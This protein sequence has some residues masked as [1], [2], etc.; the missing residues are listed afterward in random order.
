MISQLATALNTLH[1]ENYQSST[2][3]MLN[4]TLLVFCAVEA[5]FLLASYKNFLLEMRASRMFFSMTAL[6]LATFVV[7]AI[8]YFY[9]PEPHD[10]IWILAM[11]LSYVGF[12]SVLYMFIRYLVV[13]IQE[14][15]RVSSLVSLTVL[16]FCVVSALAHLLSLFDEHFISLAAPRYPV[17]AMFW[18]GNIGQFVLLLISA[19]LLLNN[20]KLVGIR[21]TIVLLLMPALLIIATVIEP[22]T[23]GLSLRYACVML[24]ILIIYT[25]HHLDMAHRYE[26]SHFDNMRSRLSLAAGRMQPH[27]IYNVLTTIYYLCD[28]DVE[29]AQTAISTFSDYLRNTLEAMERDELVS[30][31]WELSQVRNYINLERLRFGERIKIIYDIEV[32]DFLLP[33]LSIQPLVENAIRHGLA[34]KDEGG[35]L[36]LI[37]RRQMDGGVQIRV[38]DDGAGFDIAKLGTMDVT[39]EGIANARERIRLQ[40]GGDLNITSAP[41]KGTSVMVTIYSGR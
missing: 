13:Q 15:H 2:I 34:A 31:T 22:L 30:F 19:I 28:T 39:H 12:Y 9:H 7:C 16:I 33:P 20:R 32:E 11:A 24:G 14:N 21:Q 17:D 41:G 29:K 1:P 6:A 25:Q 5:F 27:Y 23:N 35:T 10:G 3:S 36:H 18:V 40:C 8:S 37:T 38:V 4:A 26:Q